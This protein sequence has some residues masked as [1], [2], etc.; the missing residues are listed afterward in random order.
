MGEED[1]KLKEG[2]AGVQLPSPSKKLTLLKK[3]IPLTGSP[4]IQMWSQP[5]VEAAY[6]ARQ[7]E[8]ARPIG[9][10]SSQQ[11]YLFRDRNLTTIN[12]R[13][14]GLALEAGS[15]DTRESC[16]V[17]IGTRVPT[18]KNNQSVNSERCTERDAR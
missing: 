9:A 1:W 4:S 10:G 16:G 18:K 12:L 7:Y 17:G 8:I 15:V 13:G 14:R 2:W 11:Q 3:T 5:E 6:C